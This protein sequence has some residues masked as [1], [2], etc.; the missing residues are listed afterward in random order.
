[1]STE[2]RFRVRLPDDEWLDEPDLTGRLADLRELDPIRGALIIGGEEAGTE[3]AVTDDLGALAQNVCFGAATQLA[4][5]RNVAVPHYDKPGYFRLDPE[6]WWVRLSGNYVEEIVVPRL[7]LVD[8]LVGCG[9]RIAAFMRALGTRGVQVDDLEEQARG[10]RAAV[11]AGPRE[12][13]G[14]PPPG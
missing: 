11:A 8:G 14:A 4:E 5:D 10:A 13:P 12:W 6:G 1:M 7:G 3:I 2:V 9:E